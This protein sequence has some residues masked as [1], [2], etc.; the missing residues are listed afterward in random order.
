[1]DLKIA[2]LCFYKTVPLLKTQSFML[3]FLTSSLCKLALFSSI[4]FSSELTLSSA[5]LV[6]LVC[7]KKKKR[8]NTHINKV[9]KNVFCSETAKCP[10]DYSTFDKS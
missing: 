2:C 6:F 10:S 3:S 7:K 1:M 4:S 5:F 8:Y 9:A